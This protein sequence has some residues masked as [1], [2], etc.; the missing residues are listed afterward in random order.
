M[1]Y[2]C[3]TS[4]INRDYACLLSAL[5]LRYIP[6]GLGC[7]DMHTTFVSY[8][9]ATSPLT[10]DI[11]ICM[12]ISCATIALHP[13]QLVMSRYASHFS[14]LPL[15]YIPTNPGC[16]NR[17]AY[18]VRNNCATSSKTQDVSKRMPSECATTTTFLNKIK[19]NR[20]YS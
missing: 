17:H 16:P 5:L 8:H 20:L 4:P 11:P 7:L 3:A 1:S 15:P 9:C 12:P 19:T 2:L 18:R 10:W 6:A 14:E 13:R